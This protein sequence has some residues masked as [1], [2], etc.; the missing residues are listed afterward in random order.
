M[1][2]DNFKLKAFVNKHNIGREI[3]YLDSYENPLIK[4]STTNRLKFKYQG[5]FIFLTLNVQHNKVLSAR[6][7]KL[8]ILDLEKEFRNLC[9]MRFCR[10]HESYMS[11]KCANIFGTTYMVYMATN[12][13]EVQKAINH[14][15]KETIKIHKGSFV[16]AYNDFTNNTDF[17]E[18]VEHFKNQKIIK[19]I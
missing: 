4:N 12:P 10:T 11:R 5:S 9:N 16:D 3:F 13:R 2:L 15:I 14:R 7:L 6:N 1:K 8:L 18:L 19:Q 17:K